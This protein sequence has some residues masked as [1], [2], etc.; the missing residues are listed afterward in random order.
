MP[1]S[2]APR[3][4]STSKDRKKVVPCDYHDRTIKNM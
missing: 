4:M 1:P 2:T 3:A